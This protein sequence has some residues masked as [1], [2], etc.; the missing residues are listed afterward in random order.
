MGG[1]PT[2]GRLLERWR[3]SRA[4]IFR[5][6][7]KERG[8][9]IVEVLIVLGISGALFIG[10]AIL[11]SGKQNQAAFNQAIQQMQSQVQQ[12]ISDVS[13]GYFPSNSNFQCTANAGG[14]VVLSGGGNAQGSNAGCVFAG[15]VL[16][17]K[18]ASTDPEKY[19]IFT[20]AGAQKDAT[21]KEVTSLAASVPKVI[22]PYV[23]APGSYPNITTDTILQNGLT[24]A[25]TGS[26]AG[27]MWYNNGGS[28]IS[29]G[30][31]AFVPSFASYT[32]TNIDS[33]SQQVSIVAIGGTATNASSQAAAT[34]IN[35]NIAAGVVNPTNGVSICFDSG[36][37]N[38]SGLLTIGGGGHPL[39][40]TMKVMQGTRTCGH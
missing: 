17:F 13:N 39:S 27:G 10:A 31:V 19:N 34:A 24:V 14:P 2:T 36:G 12:V 1:L 6:V 5:T 32:G 23:G 16:Q 4:P 22:A 25:A 35:N 21:G 11:I 29:I 18:V 26:P 9:T 37:T 3:A 8:F 38:Q 40:V 15:K 33:N 20:L 28:D 30:A 7:Q